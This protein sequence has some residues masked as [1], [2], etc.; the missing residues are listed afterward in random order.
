MLIGNAHTGRWIRTSGL[1]PAA[2]NV[3]LIVDAAGSGRA[4]GF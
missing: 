2:T 3:K 1:A 4:D